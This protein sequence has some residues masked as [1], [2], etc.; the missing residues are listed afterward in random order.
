MCGSSLHQFADIFV[1]VLPQLL[2]LP[3]FKR[4]MH[5][6]HV[7][8]SRG[9]AIRHPKL[10]R[11]VEVLVDHFNRAAAAGRSTRAIVFTQFRGSVHEILLCLKEH[12]AIQ[13][14]QRVLLLSPAAFV[15]TSL[16]PLAHATPWGCS[17]PRSCSFPFRPTGSSI[18]GPVQDKVRR[19]QETGR[20]IQ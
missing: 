2:A 20:E 14:R 18:C 5:N 12:K 16:F 1:C 17:W 6:L 13:V 7:L 19:E 15:Y 3:E 8:H 4:L 9:Q 11:L 10:Q